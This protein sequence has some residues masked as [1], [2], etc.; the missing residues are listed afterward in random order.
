MPYFGD[1][2]GNKLISARE[3]EE[4]QAAEIKK[5]LKN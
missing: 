5:K 1:I 4:V 3:G 2:Y